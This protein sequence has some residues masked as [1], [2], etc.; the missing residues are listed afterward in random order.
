MRHFVR[1]H[2]AYK[3]DSIVTDEI[4]YDLLWKMKKI[5]NDEDHCPEVL[6]RMLSKT[7]L[8]VS[9]A[10]EKDNSQLEVKRSL[11]HQ[12]HQQQL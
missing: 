7:T 4:A 9:A 3:H 12:N 8:D 5:A 2:P 10:V 11:M 6:P 1:N